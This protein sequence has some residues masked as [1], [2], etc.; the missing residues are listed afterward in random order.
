MGYRVDFEDGDVPCCGFII[1]DR[2]DFSIRSED[3][4]FIVVSKTQYSKSSRRMGYRVDFLDIVRIP[5]HAIDFP[6]R[7][8][9]ATTVVPW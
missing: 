6:I 1:W 7:S 5:W 4:C 9:D 2:I 3:S 8:E